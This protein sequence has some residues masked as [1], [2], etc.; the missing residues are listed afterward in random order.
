MKLLIKE[1]QESD[2]NEKIS[3]ICKWIFGNKYV[4]VKK[5][6]K[7]KGNYHYTGNT[8]VLRIAYVIENIVYLRKVL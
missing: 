4:E 3:Y 7:V 5:Y 1:Q 8:E 6:H 2:K